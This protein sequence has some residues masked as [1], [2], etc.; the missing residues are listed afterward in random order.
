MRK[1]I[2]WIGIIGGGLIV[3]IVALL[4]V[5]PLL[6]NLQKYKPAIE[7]QVT[8]AIGRPCTIGGD[9]RLSLFPWVGLALSD[10]H[11]GNPPGFTEKDFLD[12]KSFDVKVRL[13]PLLSKDIQVRRFVLDG[14]KV[15]LEKNKQ[16]RGNWEGIGK[17][18]EGAVP[19]PAEKRSKEKEPQKGLP[20][21]ALEVG[22]F[23]IA[24]SSIVFVDRASGTK[25]ELSK[26]NLRLIDVSLDRPIGVNL[27]AVMDGK[28]LSL[29]GQLGPVGRDP[30]KGKVL[31]DISVKALKEV[32]LHLKGS[33]IDPATNKQFDLALDVSPFS[34]RKLMSA[35]GQPFPL[36][37]T[38]P[39]A[40][41]RLALK[42]KL[43]GSPQSVDIS[44]GV[45]ELDQS[46][47]DFALKAKELSRP[48]VSFNVKLDRID[49]DRYLPPPSQERGAV[50]SKKGEPKETEPK[51]AEPKKTDYT[52]LR[53]L[54]LE[55]S[56][57]IG[58]L[59]VKNA[60]M[61]DLHL[62]VSGK[63]G[64]FRLDPVTAKLYHGTLST[65]GSVDVSQDIPKTDLSLQVKGVQAGPLVKDLTK[66]DFIEGVGDFDTV[67]GMAGADP[68][69]VKRS[70]N[71]KGELLF[72]DGAIKG[73]D[74]AG[75]V[76]NVK[77]AFG[78]ANAE[79]R[80]H[81][82]FS[83]LSVPYTITD[84]VAS[85]TKATLASPLLRVL[86]AGKADLVQEKLD[87]RVEPKFVGTLKGQGDTKKRGG[88]T[89]PVRV[90]GTFS[91]PRFEPDLKGLVEKR[92]KK[93]LLPT[94]EK[95]LQGESK[96]EK[97]E[98]TTPSDALKG[99]LKGLKPRQ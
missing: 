38:D 67:I 19:E 70:L 57:Q 5:I 56:I 3:L 88:I 31:L 76:R 7:K 33:L 11:L 90:T 21:K 99:I 53:R 72:R 48:D 25:Q 30:G 4:L 84:G 68:D 83:E 97:T 23:A 40:L 9:L 49:L 52:P 64:I 60:K 55:G 87:F 18:P 78:L 28:P 14:V 37:T 71:G 74:L 82:D 62:K 69:K 24:N 22:E 66:K 93:D 15:V 59:T 79:E 96:G 95:R 34:P 85:T 1:A 50:E 61:E 13:I 81:T 58:A 20:I 98:S 89:V 75:M 51:N 47:L 39:Q 32:D 65:K 8:K 43:K 77:A 16:G 91:S 17:G 12:V 35:I 54:V 45:L 44:D 36:S 26:V 29:D 92:L 41:D 46:K 6:V 73:I 10:L 63:N 42:A 80:P 27:S 2:K 86:A 94:L